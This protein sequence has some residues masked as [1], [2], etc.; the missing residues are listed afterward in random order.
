MSDVE[1]Q[2]EQWR[3]GLAGSETFGTDDIRELESHV[4]EEMDHLKSQG[5]SDGEAFLVARHRLGDAERLEQEFAKVDPQ[6]R[7]LSRLRWIAAGMLLWMIAG[8]ISGAAAEASLLWFGYLH[9][10]GTAGLTVVQIVVPVAIMT[11]VV[12][13]GLGWYAR[14]TRTRLR[15]G[16]GLS[17]AQM[18]ALTLGCLLLIQVLLGLSIVLRVWM[19]RPAD[20]AWYEQVKQA[21]FYSAW[22]F[23][24]LIPIL[25]TGFF[26]VLYL[27]G[28]REAPVQ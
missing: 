9:I 16:Q 22:A 19:P 8:R 2:I 20:M 3:A 18:V 17:R 14:Y 11:A 25:P 27:R 21:N 28:R 7:L 23:A 6:V 13:A 15:T 26:L 1:Q 10:L 5:L 4:R 12:A 24:F